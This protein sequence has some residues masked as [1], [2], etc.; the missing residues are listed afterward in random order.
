MANKRLFILMMR[1]I[2]FYLQ[3]SNRE[4]SLEERESAKRSIQ[5]LMG[6]NH[7]HVLGVHSCWVSREV[8][9][10]FLVLLHMLHDC[11]VY[12]SR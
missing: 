10:V 11:S 1:V 5:L 3:H 4:M 12:P 9:E 6:L 7:S 8:E 2:F